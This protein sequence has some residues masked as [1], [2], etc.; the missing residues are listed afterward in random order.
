L[1]GEWSVHVFGFIVALKNKFYVNVYNLYGVLLWIGYDNDNN[2]IF[3]IFL[4]VYCLQFFWLWIFSL[5]SHNLTNL[6]L[7]RWN[8]IGMAHIYIRDW[9]FPLVCIYVGWPTNNS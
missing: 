2:I 6:I 9:A 1:K 8:L 5:F 3:F 4:L 7:V